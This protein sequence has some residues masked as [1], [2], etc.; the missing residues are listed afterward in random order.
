[1]TVYE[2][3]NARGSLGRGRLV[4]VLLLME[5]IGLVPA[6]SHVCQVS[7]RRISIPPGPRLYLQAGV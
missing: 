2:E 1:M 7:A 3:I 5:I 6:G 4:S